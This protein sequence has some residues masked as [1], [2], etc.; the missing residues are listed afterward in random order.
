M[1]ISGQNDEQIAHTLRSS[2]KIK[3]V[4]GFALASS[5]QQLEHFVTG[6]SP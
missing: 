5:L 3:N 2:P 4:W 6:F 1:T